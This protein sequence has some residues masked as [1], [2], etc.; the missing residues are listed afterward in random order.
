MAEITENNIREALR[1]VS[2]PINGGNLVDNNRVQGIVIR[3]GNIGF[4]IEI[5]PDEAETMETARQQAEKA[6]RE[7]KGVLSATAILTS[8]SAP[9]AAA[10]T[11]QK[12]AD[13]TPAQDEKI[14]AFDR[15]KKVIAVASGKGGVGKSTVAVNLAL[16]LA[17]AGHKTGLLDADIYGPS[18]PALLGITEKPD[19]TEA[20]KLLPIERA[21]LQTMSIGYM[22]PPEQAMIWRGPMVQSALVQLLKD[23]DWPEL[24][25]LVLDLPPGTGDIQLTMAQRFPVDGA[26]IVS[27]PHALAIADVRRAVAMFH[28]VNVPVLGLVENMAYIDLPTGDTM[29]PFGA[30]I[31]ETLL[32]SLN[33]TRLAQ[34]PLAPSLQ[35]VIADGHSIFSNPATADLAAQFTTLAAHSLEEI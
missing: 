2:D 17:Q 25:V 30:P 12:Q 15:I 33:I 5:S 24:D 8:H 26:L 3:Q 16:A 34:L 14:A 20:K 35:T 6:I 31:D 11:P 4:S 10:S 7:I 13:R 23:V 1:L 19:V 28:K 21:G 22:V 27:T 32:E 29:Q 9:A 18:L